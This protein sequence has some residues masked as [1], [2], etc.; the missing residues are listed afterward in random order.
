GGAFRKPAADAG[1]ASAG[2]E[3]NVT[4]W[5]KAKRYSVGMT[6]FTGASWKVNRN[7][8]N[9]RW[10]CAVATKSNGDPCT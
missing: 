9:S 1:S 7:F 4:R 10:L 3:S 2:S 6:R 8:P 5:R